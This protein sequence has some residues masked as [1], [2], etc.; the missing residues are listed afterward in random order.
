[1]ISNWHFAGFLNHPSKHYE[2]LNFLKTRLEDDFRLK[3]F[4]QRF[5]WDLPLH[6]ESGINSPVEVGSW[7]LIIYR[8]CILQGLYTYQAVGNGIFSINRMLEPI[9]LPF[10]KFL[11]AKKNGLLSITF[12][13]KASAMLS[14]CCVGQMFGHVSSRIFGS[15]I[16]LPALTNAL[17]FRQCLKK[18]PSILALT[19]IIPQKL[20][21]FASFLNR[22][23]T[24]SPGDPGIEKGGALISSGFRW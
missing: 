20:F 4:S 15:N 12:S 16:E 13:L 9:N 14:C 6:L 21:Y 17:F 3:T 7:N 2:S 24:D 10:W 11:K 19:L 8:V 22:H 1:M 5:F 18:I 23:G